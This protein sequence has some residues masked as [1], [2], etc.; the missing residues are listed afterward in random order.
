MRYRVGAWAAEYGPAGS[1]DLDPSKTEI[2]IGVELP[3]TSWRELGPDVEPAHDVIFLDGVRRVEANVWIED[4][5]G[6]DV[7]GLAASYAAGAI[8]MGERGE[9]VAAEVGRGLFTS[10]SA[11]EP[12]VT[13]HGTYGVVTTK[14]V[15][16]EELWLGIQSQMGIVEAEVAS[17]FSDAD[18]IVVDGPLS[19]RKSPAVGYVKREHVEYLPDEVVAIKRDLST[20]KRTP[21]F[22]LGGM[23]QRFSWYLRLGP[24]RGSEGLVR[25]ELGSDR[26]VTDG[27]RMADITA[28][29]LPRYASRPHKDKRAPENLYPIGGLERT[30]RHRLGDAEL[31][32]RA[33]RSAAGRG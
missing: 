2:D 24:Y 19:P 17:R 4:G 15:S 10:A 11:A 25:C 22:L 7:L 16:P 33:L 30:L 20:G 6:G 31:M 32:L 28:A 1:S 21:L 29:T 9:L 27:I 12:I 18:L 26:P 3:A 8:R 14:G 5:S 23:H 13:R